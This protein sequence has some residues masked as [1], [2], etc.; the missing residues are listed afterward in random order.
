MG[1]PGG[2]Q[3]RQAK[4]NDTDTLAE[5]IL[6]DIPGRGPACVVH[7][8]TDNANDMVST[9]NKLQRIF[10]H[11]EMSGCVAHALDLFLEDCSKIPDFKPHFQLARDL[12]KY[13]RN[14]SNLEQHIC[15]CAKARSKSPRTG[16]PRRD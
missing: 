5:Q 2:G 10:P 12:C 11:L 13:I 15:E 4:G 1:V 9:R 16:A 14:H 3:A 6:W 7:V 8:V